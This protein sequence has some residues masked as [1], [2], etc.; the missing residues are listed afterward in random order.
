MTGE[1][2][3]SA[4]DGSQTFQA[5]PI[6]ILQE[7][8]EAYLVRLFEGTIFMYKHAK[9]VIMMPKDIQLVRCKCGERTYQNHSKNI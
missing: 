1:G 5:D 7:A 2:D 3:Y 8:T 6:A 9:R 4:D